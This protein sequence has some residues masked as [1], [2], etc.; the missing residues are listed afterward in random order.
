MF[1]ACK[2]ARLKACD[3]STPAQLRQ[4]HTTSTAALM[5]SDLLAKDRRIWADLSLVS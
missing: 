3:P 5:K 4:G 2:S 1:L